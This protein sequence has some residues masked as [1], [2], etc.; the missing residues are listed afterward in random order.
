MLARRPHARH[1]ARHTVRRLA[2]YAGKMT[3]NHATVFNPEALN[4]Y[5]VEASAARSVMVRSACVCM[6]A[7]G[8]M[9][10]LVGFLSYG[11]RGGLAGA[12]VGAEAGLPFRFHL[13]SANLAINAFHRHREERPTRNGLFYRRFFWGLLDM[14]C[15]DY[16]EVIGVTVLGSVASGVLLGAGSWPVGVAYGLATAIARLIAV[17]F[18]IEG[19]EDRHWQHVV[20][21]R[22][23]VE[24]PSP[25]ARAV[26]RRGAPVALLMALVTSIIPGLVVVWWVSG[27]AGLQFASVVA[28]AVAIYALVAFGGFALVE[29]WVL[30][31]ELRRSGLAPLPLRPFLDYATECS[32]LRRVGDDYLFVHLSLREFFAA[33]WVKGVVPA[34]QL[35]AFAPEADEPCDVP[36]S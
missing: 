18:C 6:A 32:L 24:V 31:R 9:L 36:D 26:I 10:G 3:R 30:R 7:G 23:R 27:P 2:L 29:Q 28:V 14:A 22:G 25:M 21:R 13:D 4:G 8:V 5:T 12:I 15:G 20:P 16:P 1:S 33:M 34:A 19:A 35:D 11:W 17:S